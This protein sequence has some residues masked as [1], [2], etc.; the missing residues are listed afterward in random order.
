MRKLKQKNEGITLIALVVTIVVLLI[1]AGIT[2]GTLTGDNGIIKEAKKSKSDVEYKALE[3]QVEAAIIIVEQKYRN[4]TLKQ[5][6]AEIEKI[7]TVERVNEGTG[8]VVSKLGYVIKG[9]LDDYLSPYNTALMVGSAKK[10]NKPFKTATPITDSNNKEVTIP[11]GFKIA[12]D[13]AET[14]EDGI[15]IE[16]TTANQNQFVWVPVDNINEFVRTG[17]Y[18]DGSQQS[19]TN[20]AEPFTNGYS[21]EAMNIMLCTIV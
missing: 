18:S 10:Q 4:P 16:D 9:K 11:A 17:G 13:S 21:T 2:I 5:V 6:I 3:E 7:D 15:V 1:L 12:E 14:V 8:E 20:Y 19:L